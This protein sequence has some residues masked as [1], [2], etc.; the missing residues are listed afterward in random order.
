METALFQKG[1]LQGF[2]RRTNGEY[3]DDDREMMANCAKTIE[4]LS[5]K[6]NALWEL[7][8][9]A[10]AAALTFNK[11]VGAELIRER[12]RLGLKRDSGS[13]KP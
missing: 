13:L 10:I 2:S 11:K 9:K 12:S 3:T 1:F 4:S 8:D 7:S 5:T 6:N